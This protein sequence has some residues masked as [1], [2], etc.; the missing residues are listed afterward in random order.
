MEKLAV[1]PTADELSRLHLE[2]NLQTIYCTTT[3]YHL[4]PHIDN[5]CISRCNINQSP[6]MHINII[7]FI[8]LIPRN[9][10]EINV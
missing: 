4:L 10:I 5:G 6:E 8:H 9:K 7:G 3:Y 1:L 2:L